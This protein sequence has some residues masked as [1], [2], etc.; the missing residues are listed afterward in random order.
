MDHI[1]FLIIWLFICI[2]KEAFCI[3]KERYADWF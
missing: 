2:H 3:H 1:R